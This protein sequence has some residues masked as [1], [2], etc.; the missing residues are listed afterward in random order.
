MRWAG[1]LEVVEGP[2]VDRTPLFLPENDPFV[3]RFRVK[4]VP[5]LPLE[6]AIPIHEDTVFGT[7]SFTSGKEG[8]YWLGPLRR[9]LQHIEETDGAFL[10]ELLLRQG[11]ERR[12]YALDQAELDQLKP[13]HVKRVDGTVGV[14]VPRTNQMLRQLRL[15]Q[16]VI[17]SRTKRTWQS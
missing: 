3:L 6:Q 12:I 11:M 13:K 8:G 14:T 2:V 16:V 1:V 17:R 7:L 15:R 4:A 5:A 9:S 10:E